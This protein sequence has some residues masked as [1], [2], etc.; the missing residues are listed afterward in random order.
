VTLEVEYSGH[1]VSKDGIRVNPKK[2]MA[3]KEWPRPKKFK[4]LCGFSRLTGYY[5]MFV[6]NYAKFWLP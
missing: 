2:V 3:M 6:N 4:S 5:R 1:V